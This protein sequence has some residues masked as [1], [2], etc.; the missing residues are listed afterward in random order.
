MPKVIVETANM[1]RMEW[2]EARRKVR[3]LG[4]SDMSVVLGLNKWK[5]PFQLW[6]EKTGQVESDELY[7]VDEDGAF[8]SGNEA[9]YWGHVDEDIVAKEFALRHKKKVRR[10]NAILQHDEYDFLF[11]NIDREIVGEDA[12][13]EC[14][15]TSAYNAKEWT[16]DEIPEAYIVQCQ[17]YMAV[18]GKK[19]WYIACKIG[20]NKF[21]SKLISRD[22]ELIAIIIERAKHFWQH[23]VLGNVPPAIDGSSAAEKFLNERYKKAEHGKVVELGSQYKEKVDELLQLKATIKELDEQATAI[24][25]QLKH[26]LQQA[27]I[28]LVHGYEIKWTS[29]S[30][31]RI[32]SNALKEKYPDIAKEVTKTI[33]SRKFQIKELA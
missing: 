1:S 2:L 6:L 9:A 21:V 4:G 31:G 25:N 26:E 22:D 19:E 11:A 7:I 32:D 27:E 17:H 8:V 30:Q 5:T 18:T 12:G 16:G 29:Y 23:H 15:I 14:K 33:Q 28:G 10:R 20:G 24:E 3:G 13:L